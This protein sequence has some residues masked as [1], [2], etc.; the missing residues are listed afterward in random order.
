MKAQH[1][2]MIWLSGDM[3]FRPS[4]LGRE[5][6]LKIALRDPVKAAGIVAELNDGSRSFTCGRSFVMHMEEYRRS[7]DIWRIHEIK[8]WEHQKAV[9]ECRRGPG[10][11]I[12]GG[13]FSGACAA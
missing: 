12:L 2:A 4:F 9:N 10:G 11:L 8:K 13:S 5:F 7:P 6:V 3:P 1:L